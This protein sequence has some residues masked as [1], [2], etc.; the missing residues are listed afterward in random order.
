MSGLPVVS[1]AKT[2]Q[3][4]RRAG[5]QKPPGRRGQRGSHV[6]L[7]HPTTGR[8]AIVPQHPELAVG[9]LRSVLRQAGLT[10]EEFRQLL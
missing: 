1:G 10:A 4:L 6:K 5:F 9:T 7:R 2:V 8:T 3:A